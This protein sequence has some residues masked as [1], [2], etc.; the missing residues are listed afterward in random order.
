[1][2]RGIVTGLAQHVCG[3]LLGHLTIPNY[4]CRKHVRMSKSYALQDKVSPH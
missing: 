1:M 4:L 3:Y 2:G